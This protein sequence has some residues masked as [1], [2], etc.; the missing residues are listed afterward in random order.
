MWSHCKIQSWLDGVLTHWDVSVQVVTTTRPAF[1][2]WL[3][4]GHTAVHP[5]SGCRH[6]KDD[7][8]WL[9][10]SY[11][12][13]RLNDLS[14]LFFFPTRNASF[15]SLEWV[16]CQVWAQTQTAHVHQ[17]LKVVLL[18]NI[19]LKKKKKKTVPGLLRQGFG[20]IHCIYWRQ[21]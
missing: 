12:D 1:G 15:M 18:N 9:E 13:K 10:N 3:C 20:F 8:P 11:N 16:C 5:S 7:N 14:N 19:E 17:P 6:C 4:K 21:K 2:P